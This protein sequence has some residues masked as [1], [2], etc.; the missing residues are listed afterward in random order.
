METAVMDSEAPAAAESKTT[1]AGA[2]SSGGG[3]DFSQTNTQVAGVDESDMV[4]TDGSYL[5]YYNETEK[6]VFILDARDT[7]G[8]P[9]LVKKIHL[10]ENFYNPQLYVTNN[11]LVIIASGY[12]QTDYSKMGYYINRNSKTYTIVFD[13]TDKN[14]TSLLKLYSSD[15]DYKESRRIGDT[16]YVLSNNSFSFPFYNYKSEDD[17]KIDFEKM[18]PQ[19][20][21]ISKTSNT[22]EQNLVLQNKELPYKVAQG[23]VVNCNNISYSLPDAETLKKVGFNP[24]YTIISRIDLKDPAQEVL[25]SVVAGNNNEIH[26]S[27]KNLYMTEAIYEPY[28]YSCPPNARCAM[29]FFWGGNQNTLIH[30]LNIE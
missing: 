18:L 27:E 16:L 3:D 25:T 26:M 28:N 15:G 13:T 30:K 4:K 1:N 8:A 17:I 23:N 14:N 2:S 5:Y 12:S 29:P 21:D 9:K 6:S 24:G 11:R 19:K 10:P 22:K 7:T 20:L